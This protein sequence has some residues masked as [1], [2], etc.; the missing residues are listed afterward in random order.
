[1]KKF[2]SYIQADAKDCGPTCL[3]IVAKY[4]G[5]TLNIQEL[6]DFSETTREGSN[7]LFLSDA[8]E[9]IGFRTLGV[10]LN[11][12]RLDEAPLPCILHW[13]KEHYVVLYEVVTRKWGAKSFIARSWEFVVGRNTK[14]SH[15][16]LQATYKI[17]DP[18]FGL[19]EYNQQDFIKFWI[20]NNADNFTQEGIALLLEPTPN[21]HLPTSDFSEKNRQC[22]RIDRS[23]YKKR[24][25]F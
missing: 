17:S 18:A 24:S 25:I 4:F 5:K 13:N 1:M 8:A 23:K 6:R 9:K 20:G 14:T 3:K 10:K 7:L 11:V 16:Q 22:N 15:S 2:P 12:A 21:F 19:I